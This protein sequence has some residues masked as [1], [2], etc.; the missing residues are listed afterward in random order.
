MV[1]PTARYFINNTNNNNY[2]GFEMKGGYK[3]RLTKLLLSNH[4][5][6]LL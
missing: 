5:P 6:K 2:M 3:S 4:V 1:K